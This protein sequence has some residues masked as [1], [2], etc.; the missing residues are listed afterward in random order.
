MKI[1]NRFFILFL[2][3]M[4]FF[5]LV[6]A[7]E[8]Q[9]KKSSELQIG[10]II[11]DSNGNEIVVEKIVKQGKVQEQFVYENS[12]S[13]SNV[14]W[15][16]IVGRDLPE[17]IVSGGSSSSGLSLGEL[18]VGVRISGEVVADVPSSGV[19]KQKS[20]WQ[21]LIFWRGND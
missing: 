17:P 20:F 9:L 19:E 16:K 14:L 7:A 18:G 3:G 15:G 4:M 13:L 5:S 10:D 21:K 8:Y 6:C 12:N 11:V 2:V 1:L